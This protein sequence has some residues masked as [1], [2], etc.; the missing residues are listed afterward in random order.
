MSE[1]ND[2]PMSRWAPRLE[3]PVFLSL[4]V[5]V[6]VVHLSLLGTSLTGM[7]P[8]MAVL[9]KDWTQY[10][11]GATFID[12][13]PGPVLMLASLAS[14]AGR[15]PTD[16][17]PFVLLIA[18]VCL[19]I[20]FWYWL[21]SL[22]PSH[23]LAVTSLVLFVFLP[24]HNSYIGFDNYPVLFAAAAFFGA[25]S[26]WH[27]TIGGPCSIRSWLGL[28]VLTA[29]IVQFRGEYLVFLP[30][31][32]AIFYGCHRLSHGEFPPPRTSAAALV[33]VAALGGGICGV[34]LFR[35]L[36]SGQLGLVSKDYTCWAFLDGT[37]PAWQKPGDGSEADRVRSGMEHFGHP[38]QYGYSAPSM[39]WHHRGKTLQKFVLNLPSWLYELGRRHV[40]VPLPLAALAVLGAVTAVRFRSPTL[41]ETRWPAAFA[42][43][44][45]TLPLAGLIISA[46]YMIPASGAM[47][48]LAA[49]G[50]LAVFTWLHR[51]ACRGMDGRAIWWIGLAVT[52]VGLELL[53]LRGGGLLRD[54]PNMRRVASYVEGRFGGP[55]RV[56][57][58]LDPYSDNIDAECRANVCNRRI[59]RELGLSMYGFDPRDPLAAATSS[60]AAALGL[61][62][63][64][65]WTE[66]NGDAP[67]DRE[68]LRQ[69][70]QAGFRLSQVH[71]TPPDDLP[72]FTMFVLCA[73]APTS[74][75][76][77]SERQHDIPHN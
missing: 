62:T 60:A 23:D 35:Q 18:H 59:Y 15:P 53:L 5:L 54:A 48:V 70:E 57:L 68:R 41:S 67:A 76:E 9:A 69:W 73:G 61:R 4:V 63:A 12:V 38:A 8:K 28:L 55:Q 74:A 47:C 39:A 58:V 32:L 30:L 64:V 22:R 7:N 43:I 27:A 45:M 26:I 10:G 14:F 29:S 66:G 42:A 77:G 37:P 24:C 11:F 33:M 50:L 31:Y 25:T 19:A 56:P 17:I 52:C 72:R 13:P 46:R 40:V 75:E 51:I 21:R 20:G 36:E 3:L 65:F 2:A 44:L 1:I 49:A 16:L 34:L 6:R 71:T